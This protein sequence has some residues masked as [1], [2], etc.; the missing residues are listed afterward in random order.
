MK[1]AVLIRTPV[2]GQTPG[3]LVMLDGGKKVLESKTLEL[4]WKD[5]KKNESCIPVGS[6]L[7][8]KVTSPTFGECFEVT[9]V[10]GRSAILI[11]A[12]NFRRDTRGCIL[13]GVSFKDVDGDGLTD[14]IDSKV[15]LD[16]LKKE[17]D[18]FILKIVE[19]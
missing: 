7:V 14:V 16:K 5:N 8:K 19:L 15:A 11:H 12:G 1:K 2:E 4:P 10:E 17:C 9:G 13:P 6:Y 3:T 18:C